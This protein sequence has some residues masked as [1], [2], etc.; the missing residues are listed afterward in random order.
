M[1]E[2]KAKI[3]TIG[4][5]PYV[6]LPVRVLKVIFKDAGKDRGKIPVKMKI[7]GHEF[8]Q[9]LIRYSGEWRLYLNTPMRDAADKGV[10]DQARFA[11]EHDP[12][13]RSVPMPAKLKKAL[14]ENPG[15]KKTFDSL[16]PS[17]QKEIM[18]YI[19]KLKSDEAVE[20]N[21]VRAI[22]FLSGKD[23]FVGVAPT[24]VAATKKQK[25]I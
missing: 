17:R 22:N 1:Q 16:R 7:E 2:F 9:T 25:P 12:I 13:P 21:V 4:V 6:L 10:G 18:R 5:N 3:E 20:K 8:S 11:I 14:G 19:A 24:G 15:A 23:R